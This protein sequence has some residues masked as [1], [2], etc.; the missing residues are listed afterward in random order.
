[1]N[2]KPKR[3]DARTVRRCVQ[4]CEAFLHNLTDE[5]ENQATPAAYSNGTVRRIAYEIKA[6]GR[7][8]EGVD[9]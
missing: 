8:T 4:I 2:P 9:R 6:L 1:M 7:A 3:Y 5:E